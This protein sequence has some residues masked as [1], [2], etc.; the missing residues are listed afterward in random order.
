MEGILLWIE[1]SLIFGGLMVIFLLSLFEA[2]LVASSRAR[3][4]AMI[5]HSTSEAQWL[6][7]WERLRRYI[8]SF[9][10]GCNMAILSTS[11]LTTHMLVILAP[12][13]AHI[14]AIG[15]FLMLAFI[16][17]VCEITP[18]AYSMQYPERVLARWHK[19]LKLFGE[20]LT[21]FATSF[22]TVA[23]S[24][25]RL[26][27]YK[28]P[29]EQ[30]KLTDEE[31]MVLLEVG[32]GEDVIQKREFDIASSIMRLD[33]TLVREVMV[34]RPD[35]V[36]L[37]SNC[38]MDDVVKLIVETGHSRIPL[39]EGDIDNIVGVIYAY[40]ILSHWNR[41]EFEIEPRQIMRT[42][43]YVPEVKNLR[44]LLDEMR[45]SR[46]HIAIVID[47]YGSTAGLITLEDIVEQVVG[48][49]VDEHDIEV[50]QIQRLADGS[51]I[52]DASLSKSEVH[53]KLGI[54]LPEGDYETL[55][56][57]VLYSLGR[58]PQVGERVE[59]DG[60]NIIVEDVRKRRVTKVRIIIQHKADETVPEEGNE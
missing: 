36:A 35:I 26:I 59:V 49:L 28:E 13:K 50:P 20:V 42:P 19:L 15:T 52:V 53:D 38:K 45:T 27:G 24:F 44:E 60:V 58:I 23:H 47:E 11:A 54:S 48:E 4:Q 39:Y 5:S 51:Y 57:F 43:L 40:D 33:R 6:L 16:L 25:L 3:L 21:P 30:L 9:V 34:P 56:G 14:H 10:V 1:A 55:G 37:P 17:S 29:R 2:A 31:I 41:G 22:T 8:P 32:V 18:K 12:G 46:V 7:D